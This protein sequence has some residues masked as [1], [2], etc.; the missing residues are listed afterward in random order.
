MAAQDFLAGAEEGAGWTA[1]GALLAWAAGAGAAAEEPTSAEGADSVDAETE[2]GAAAAAAVAAE[3]APWVPWD[4]FWLSTTPTW[5]AQEP[6]LGAL[7]S[8]LAALAAPA[9]AAGGAATGFVGMAAATGARLEAAAAAVGARLAPA[10]EVPP[11]L[12]DRSARGPLGGIFCE[13]ETD[14]CC[15]VECC[16]ATAGVGAAAGAGAGF[17]LGTFFLTSPHCWAWPSA[18]RMMAFSRSPSVSDRTVSRSSSFQSGNNSLRVTNCVGYN[19]LRRLDSSSSIDVEFLAGR[20]AVRLTE[21]LF[22]RS[23]MFQVLVCV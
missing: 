13:V 16:W 21:L 19:C 7:C 17:S 20:T 9:T 2:T 5:L 15:D 8:V 4:S 3:E 22:G 6:A 10:A 14:C 11:T 1:T 12:A 18:M 23:D